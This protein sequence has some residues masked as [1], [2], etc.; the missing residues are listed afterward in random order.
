MRVFGLESCPSGTATWPWDFRCWLPSSQVCSIR[1]TSIFDSVLLPSDPR[2]FHIPLLDSR[3]WGLSSLPQLEISS[4]LV[5][6]WGVA[7]RPRGD[8]CFPEQLAE[9][10]SNRGLAPLGHFELGETSSFELVE[11]FS[12]VHLDYR[13]AI[14]S[15]FSR[16][17]CDQHGLGSS[18][19][20][21]GEAV[22]V[23]LIAWKA[24]VC[25]NSRES[26]S[27]GTRD[28]PSSSHC[29]TFLGIAAT[30]T[31]PTARGLALVP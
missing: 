29:R 3:D 28:G 16:T 4:L 31:N 21:E 30:T 27:L 23:H 1:R 18:R 24:G 10:L 9:S 6:R 14:S 15:R 12:S 25:F 17:I 8:R 19:W 20:N 2:H 13:D 11:E 22:C 7:V 5:N 26:F